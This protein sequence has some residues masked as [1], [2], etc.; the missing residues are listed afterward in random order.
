[1][2]TNILADD[3]PLFRTTYFF[4]AALAGVIGLATSVITARFFVIGLERTEADSTTREV[5]ILAGV[6]MIVVELAAFFIAALLPRRQLRALRWQL[7]ACA[8]LLVG[9]EFATIATTQMVMAQSADA[10]HDGTS[11][12][13]ASLKATIA[14]QRAAAAALVATGTRS[15]QSVIASSRA[16]GAQALRE[17]ARIEGRTAALSAELERLQAAQ[18]PTLTT[19]LGEPLTLAY[20]CARAGLITVMGLVMFAAAGALL[21]AGRQVKASALPALVPAFASSA[22]A[23]PRGAVPAVP[24]GRRWAAAAG[25]GGAAAMAAPAFA[26]VPTMIAP[27]VPIAASAST[28]MHTGALTSMQSDADAPMVDAVAAP[29]KK[30]RRAAAPRAGSVRDTGVGENDGARFLRVKEG[31]EAGRIKPSQRA[32]YA[33]EGASQQVARRYLGQLLADGVI[34]EQG[35]GR[36]YRVMQAGWM[37]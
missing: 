22:P 23:L 31:V 21:R 25:L 10:V 12:R 35:R 7:T 13:I 8:V 5:L 15:G 19:V 3:S 27:A 14:G 2:T 28:S 9:F 32:I 6:L 11:G 18:R 34:V 29:T 20:N 17:A 36:G 37:A 30:A 24:T 33:A 1:M 4:L 16:E 26:A